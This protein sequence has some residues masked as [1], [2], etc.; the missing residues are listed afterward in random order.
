MAFEVDVRRVLHP[1]GKSYEMAR[2]AGRGAS[3]CRKACSSTTATASSRAGLVHN[4]ALG[5]TQL[6]GP[7]G[8]TS[9]GLQA[10]IARSR[11]EVIITTTR[12]SCTEG[13]RLDLRLLLERVEH[14]HL[15][16]GAMDKE[17]ELSYETRPAGTGRTS[18]R[19]DALPLRPVTE[20]APPPHWKWVVVD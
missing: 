1:G 11:G 3:D 19:S 17:G 8:P 5:A 15:Q 12:S 2:T 6:P 18:S 20:R 10:G 9:D 13:G 14:D 4:H 7:Q 16:Q